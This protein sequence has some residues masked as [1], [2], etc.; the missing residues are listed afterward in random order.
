MAEITLFVYGTL[1]RGFPQNRLLAGQQFL[2]EAQTVSG[3]RLYD[4]GRHPCLV[5]DPKHG[6]VVCGELWTVDEAILARLD[7]YEEVPHL[8][9]RQGI[10]IAGFTTPVEAYFFQGDVSSLKDCGAAWP[11]SSA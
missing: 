9:S 11:G 5:S 7:E 4:N 10:N 6:A 2:G 3:Y 1:K 8:F